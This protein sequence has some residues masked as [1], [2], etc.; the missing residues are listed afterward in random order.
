M[1]KIKVALFLGIADQKDFDGATMTLYT[2]IDLL[3]KDSVEFLI[4]T[5]KAPEYSKE[6]PHKYVVEPSMKLPLYKDYP[7]S[8]PGLT[9]KVRNELDK[10]EPDIVHITTPLFSGPWALRYAKKR[11]IPVLTIYHTHFLKYIYYYVG[12]IR[13]LY[14]LVNNAW[15]RHFKKF[16]NSVDKSLVPTTTILEEL[17]EIGVKK[18]KMEIWGRGI[19]LELF[20]PKAKSDAI[21]NIVKNDKKNIFFVSRLVWVK[22]LETL[23]GVYK[24]I[25]KRRDDV[26]FVIAGDGPQRDYLES[27]MPEAFFLGKK[28]HEELPELYA[29]S[30][31]FIFPSISETFG[32]VVQEAMACGCPPII[33]AAGGPKGIVQDGVTGLHAKPKDVEDF[34]KQI[35]KLLDD[36]ELRDEISRDDVEYA[37]QQSWPK[38][39]K[40]LL[41]NYESLLD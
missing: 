29:S 40:R 18:E 20:N 1:K 31:I 6:F 11:S 27:E 2:V 22:E 14:L 37:Q 26:N 15:Q 39:S 16:Y 8:F 9:P 12:K 32:N 24:E 36:D 35:N 4:V 33:A 30:D 23:A 28:R 25:M 41:E 7:I 17:E 21:R 5:S 13:P 19:D 10:F 3:P 34:V 38:L